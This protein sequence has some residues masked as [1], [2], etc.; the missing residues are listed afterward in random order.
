[1]VV[2]GGDGIKAEIDDGIE[3]KVEVANRQP[4]RSSTRFGIGTSDQWHCARRIGK[5]AILQ[6]KKSPE[7]SA[8]GRRFSTLPCHNIF[9]AENLG[10]KGRKFRQ[11]APSAT[12]KV[13]GGG[14]G[15]FVGLMALF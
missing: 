12:R 2:G 15:R 3:V 4:R 5:L 6:F 14:G 8:V 13:R 11:K 7:W 9:P 10:E 1:M